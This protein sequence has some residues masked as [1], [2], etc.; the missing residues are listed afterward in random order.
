MPQ[1]SMAKLLF[2]LSHTFTRF[3]LSAFPLCVLAATIA[4]AGWYL[5]A[6]W[7]L[8]ARGRSWNSWRSAA[9]LG[10]LF[11]VDVAFCSSVALYAGTYFQA[12]I[13][14]HL[15][16]MVVAPPLLALGA[17]ST[18]LL[19]T[20]RR[21]TKERWLRVLRSNGFAA[22]SHPV[23]VFFLYFGAM[24]A[25]F[26]TSLIGYAMDH[27][28]LMDLI[29]VVFLA[30]G[31]LYWWPMVGIDPILHWKMSHGFRLINI[32]IGGGVEAFLGVAILAETRPVA[33]MYTLASTRSGG[34]LLWVATEFVS[35]GA[36][37]PIF[38]QWMR[39]EERIAVRE[40]RR[41]DRES[42]AAAESGAGFAR[43]SSPSWQESVW[44]AAFAAKGSA[45]P[46]L[47]DRRPD[48]ER[49]PEALTETLPGG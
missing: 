49:L 8:A 37:V 10:G 5:R 9:F 3:D 44:Q 2:S 15:L 24:F 28:A 27:M 4:V 40:D 34:A 30:G 16:L 26:L 11:S 25:F 23:T 38:M 6:E 7:A 19:Q 12:H 43:P 46:L 1:M 47:Q 33:P 41:L 31:T 17:P 36:F 13:I 39:S 42:A 18:L 22:L 32:L 20:A 14:Q 48:P 21:S 45:V 29:N 35:L